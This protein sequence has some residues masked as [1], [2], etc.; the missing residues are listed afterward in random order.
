MP[1]SIVIYAT[2]HNPGGYPRTDGSK[3]RACSRRAGLSEGYHI[4]DF[5]LHASI[6]GRTGHAL[7]EVSPVLEPTFGALIQN[8]LRP[9]LPNVGER[10]DLRG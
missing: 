8:H 5:C 7:V 10:V 1:T 6:D 4:F 9:R 2:T 3:P